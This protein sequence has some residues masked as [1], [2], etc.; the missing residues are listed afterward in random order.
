MAAKAKENFCQHIQEDFKVGQIQFQAL[1]KAG[2]YQGGE[3]WMQ[4]LGRKEG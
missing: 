4:R 2:F 3:T 1:A